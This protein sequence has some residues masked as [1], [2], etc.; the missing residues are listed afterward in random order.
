MKTN[1]ISDASALQDEIA[2]LVDTLRATERRLQELTDGEVDSFLL[3]GGGSYLLQD[4]QQDLRRSEELFRSVFFNSA[5]GIAISTPG[6]QY[7]HVN[8]TYCGMLGYARE[9][10]LTIN[11]KSL[12]HPDD[13]ALNLQLVSEILS[14]QRE[15]MSMEKRYLKKTGELLWVNA[16]V[17]ASHTETGEIE[18][19]T[20]VAVDITERKLAEFRLKR[21]NRLHTVLGN[22]G[23]AIVRIQDSQAL[24]EAACRTIV[25]AGGLRMVSIARVD[26]AAGVAMPA[27]SYGAG[28]EYLLEPTCVVPTDDGPLS[29][30]TLGTALRTG[31]YDVCNNIPGSPRMAPWHEA[32]RQHGMLANA[33][34]PL[35]VRGAI[36]GVMVL[37]AG[38]LDYFLDDELGLMSAVAHNI[39]LALEAIE[40]GKEEVLAQKEVQRKQARY[41]RLID[42]NVQGV[43]FWDRS[44]RITGAND[45]FLRDI[46]CT[47]EDLEAGRL[48]W[49]GMTPPE[50]AQRDR[51][52]LE[53]LAEKGF[54]VPYEKEFVLSDGSRLPVLIGAATFPDNPEEGVCFVL[55]LTERKKLEQQFLRAQRTESIGTLAGGIAH[56]LNNVLAPIMMSIELLKDATHDGSADKILETIEA[57]AARGAEIVRQVLSYARGMEGVRVEVHTKRLLNELERIITDTFPKD[58][59]LKFTVAEDVW[60]ILGDPTQVQQ[61]LLNLAVN[62]RDAMP[63]GGTLTIG[64]ENRVLD[65][66]TSPMRP[67]SLSGNYVQIIVTDSGTGIPPEIMEKIFE[68][69]FTTKELGKG[70]G[71]GLSTV[72]AIVKS[73]QGIVNV[74]SEPGRGTAFRVYLPAVTSR[75]M[76]GDAVED[77]DLFIQGRGETILVVD[78]EPGIVELARINLESYGYQVLTAHDGAQGLAV[79]AANMQVISAVLTDI[80]MPGMDGV[81]MVQAMRKM[82]P[83]IKVVAAS[84]LASNDPSIP[85]VKHVLPKPYRAKALL[86]VMRTILDED[87]D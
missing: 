63:N 65:G 38:E 27:A 46:R 2:V 20:V 31:V 75:S 3:K 60:K 48:S 73:H 1:P 62:A 56:D 86:T 29:N 26:A 84:G 32:A 10:L 33:S 72:M 79:Y 57:S 36:V 13:L 7:L 50:L 70:T 47:R 34:F 85:G 42:S 45:A 24:Y 22:I 28:V 71:L 16:S 64:A 6:G 18:T 61:I 77:P 80:M 9:E 66:H 43:M 11:F 17:A 53:E 59:R 82:N 69:F 23:E 44:G 81:A 51:Q 41:Q 19:L 49:S 67:E 21:L 52:A 35:K 39:S 30:G 14:G 40:I 74:Y 54:C 37:Y 58:I 76:P 68:P 5:T 8:D 87:P 4:A 55:N 78:D 25:E 12:T 83:A 15:Y